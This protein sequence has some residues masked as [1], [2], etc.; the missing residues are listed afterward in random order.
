MI[1][2]ILEDIFKM[3]TMCSVDFDISQESSIPLSRIS[4]KTK[5][6][7]S[8]ARDRPDLIQTAPVP[9]ESL[10]QQNKNYLSDVTLVK[11][12]KQTK[13]SCSSPSSRKTKKCQSN[14]GDRPDLI[15]T[16]PVL[17]IGLA[18][19]YKNKQNKKLKIKI[20]YTSRMSL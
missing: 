1:L 11:S 4:T 6:C 13:L 9:G 15:Q 14:A 3:C 19:Q 16:A 5:K 17:S 8:E 20:K 18:G 2:N 10:V 7:H 12:T